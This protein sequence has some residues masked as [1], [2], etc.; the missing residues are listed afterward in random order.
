MDMTTQA[1]CVI[2]Q[3][4]VLSSFFTTPCHAKCEKS[5]GTRADEEENELIV[6]FNVN[7]WVCWR[8]VLKGPLAICQRT[9]SRPIKPQMF[10][11]SEMWTTD[12]LCLPICKCRVPL[13]YLN[14]CQWECRASINWF[15]WSFLCSYSSCSHL[16]HFSCKWTPFQ[17]SDLTA[18][19]Y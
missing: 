13:S 3:R 2:I 9:F 16:C 5:F 14:V 18:S 12:L 11:V 8:F 6:W 15:V 4:F 10:I 1:V 19:C 7:L 17:M